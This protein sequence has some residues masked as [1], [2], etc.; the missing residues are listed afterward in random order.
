MNIQIKNVRAILPVGKGFEV[1]QTDVY[2]VGDTIASIGVMPTDFIAEKTIDGKDKLLSAGLINAHT[3]SYMSIFRNVADDLLFEDWLFKNIMP[4]EDQLVDEDGYWGAMLG[5]LEMIKTGTTSFIDMHLFKNAIPRAVDKAGIKCVSTRGLV[6]NGRNDKGGIERINVTKEEIAQWKGN[7]RISFMMG[8]HAIYS[9]DAGYLQLVMESAVECGV[10]LNIHLSETRNEVKTAYE[11]YGCSPV[12]YLNNMGF[13][14]IKTVAAH[15]VHLSE[16]DIEILAEKQ[17]AVATNP[18]SNLKLGNGFAPIPQMLEKG[19]RLAIGTDSAASNNTLNMFSDMN[20]LSLIHK[21]TTETATA[22]SAS[23][24]YAMATKGGAFAMNTMDTGELA[25]G[26]K[27]DL[28]LIDLNRPQF[29][30]ITNLVSAMAYSANGSEIDTMI[31]D[32]EIVME[33]GKVLT[34]DE[35]EI[36][37]NAQRIIDRIKK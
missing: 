7:K 10:G 31:V 12:E 32:G 25:V 5:C 29:Q 36:Y 30:P 16:K 21:G 3:H 24:T 33:N 2:I 20:F 17:V 26:K 4:M 27:A 15:C 13:F 37:F 18:I 22:V 9:T 8:P 6:G 34:L 19:V 28:I 11:K 1:K 23:E 35:E 14:D